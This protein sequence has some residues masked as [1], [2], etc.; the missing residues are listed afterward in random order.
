MFV[1]LYSLLQP[2]DGR[3]LLLLLLHLLVHAIL[4]LVVPD[5]EIQNG[6]GNQSKGKSSNFWEAALYKVLT[7]NVIA[8]EKINELATLG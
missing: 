3:K 7:Y 8:I 4:L 1:D 6:I 5:K 2:H